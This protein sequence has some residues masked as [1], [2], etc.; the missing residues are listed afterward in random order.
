MI[1]LFPATAAGEGNHEAEVAIRAAKD[2]RRMEDRLGLA[3]E[4]LP[5]SLRP[6][7]ANALAVL[8]DHS[9]RGIDGFT[10]D[11][12]LQLAKELH[13]VLEFLF[14]NWRRQ[15]EDAARFKTTV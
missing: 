12:C 14:K 4:V 2:G 3:S 11:E 6:A 13:F 9:S 8:Y 10:N 5:V 15:M 7:G 1:E